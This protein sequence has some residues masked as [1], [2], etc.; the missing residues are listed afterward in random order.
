MQ[1]GVPAAEQRNNR[2]SGSDDFVCLN[3]ET[4]HTKKLH[5]NYTSKGMHFC[6]LNIQ[7]IIPKLDELRIVMA[8]E[9]CPDILGVCETFLS[10]NILNNQIQIKGYDFLRKDRADILSKTGGDILLYFR[11]SV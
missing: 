10:P 8:T 9:N 3:Y 11:N 6:N 7:H 1:S 2:K 4:S 5:L